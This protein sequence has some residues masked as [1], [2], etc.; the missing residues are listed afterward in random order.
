MNVMPR[1]VAAPVAPEKLFIGGQWVEPISK[2]RLQVISPVT[3]ER[4]LNYPEA[5]PADIDRAVAEARD[6]FDNGPWPRMAPAERAR[7][8][9]KV[10]ELLTERLDDIAN[11]WTLQVGAPIMLTKKLVGQNPTLFNYYADLIETLSVR[12]RAQARRWRQGE[13]GEGAGRCLRRDHA[14]ECAAGAAELQGGGRPGGRLHHRIEAFARDA[15][16]GLHPRRVHRE[17]RI[18]RGRV[19]PGAGRPR[20]RRLSCAS[21]GRRQGGL[22]RLDRRRQAHRRRLRA[23]PRARQPGAWRQVAGDSARRCGFLGGACRA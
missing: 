14:V 23:A 9:R 6:A 13:G 18:A 7:Y 1:I 2:Q 8:L 3:E 22:H 21:Q 11:A 15:A 12:G 16:G 19:Q 17:G 20:G 10:A 4:I 5:G